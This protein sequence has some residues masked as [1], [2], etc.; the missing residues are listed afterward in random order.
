[1]ENSQ[2]LSEIIRNNLIETLFQPIAD[3][4]SGEEIG[5][6]AFSRG[7]EGT[8]LY[9]PLP[10]ISQAKSYCRID[11]LDQLL[12]NNALLHAKKQGIRSLL[13][14]NLCPEFVFDEDNR[15]ILAGRLKEYRMETDRI[16]IEFSVKSVLSSLDGFI[17]LVEEYRRMGFLICLDNVG[18]SFREL[19]PLSKMKPDFVKIDQASVTHVE[20]DPEK[21]SSLDMDVMLTRFIG[22]QM[23]AVGVETPQELKML[24]R[25]GV[26]AAQGMLI[27]APG[28]ELRGV[29]A[30]ARQL[31][32]GE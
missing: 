32:T 30:E 9:M 15:R 5:Y 6:E 7:P 22:A 28:R 23:I 19:F 1:M 13:F 8:E 16:V 11:E 24:I 10:L 29:R 3:L 25:L 27:G 17:R 31:I 2:L 26:G 14:L 18:S 12:S 21:Q 20:D 4:K